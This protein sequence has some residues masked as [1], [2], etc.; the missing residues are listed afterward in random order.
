[1]HFFSIWIGA[2]WLVLAAGTRGPFVEKKFGGGILLIT[3]DLSDFLQCDART[4]TK[5]AVYLHMTLH[6]TLIN[7]LCF[8]V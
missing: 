5:E 1:M 8:C 4:Q 3:R 6:P 2:A 7:G